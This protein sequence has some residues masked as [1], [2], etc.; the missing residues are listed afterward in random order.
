MIEPHLATTLVVGSV[1]VLR[2]ASWIHE[3]WR[4]WIKPAKPRVITLASTYDEIEEILKTTI[5]R[6][7]V[8]YAD[9]HVVDAQGQ[10][11]AR[12]QSV[13]LETGEIVINLPTL[14]GIAMDHNDLRDGSEPIAIRIG[15]RYLAIMVNDTLVFSQAYERKRFVKLVPS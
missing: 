3:H 15:M 9:V 7:D 1:I 8:A 10:R 13:D 12:V 14:H 5:P 11:I 4:A 2:Y 6:N